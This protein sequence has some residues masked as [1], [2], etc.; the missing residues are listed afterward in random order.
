MRAKSQ[1]DDVVAVGRRRARWQPALRLLRYRGPAARRFPFLCR[2]NAAAECRFYRQF[3]PQ[4]AVLTRGDLD[5]TFIKGLKTVGR[6]FLSQRSPLAGDLV[7]LTQPASAAPTDRSHAAV[8]LPWRGLVVGDAGGG[9][10]L[11]PA[12]TCNRR[13]PAKAGGGDVGGSVPLSRR[14]PHH[15]ASTAPFLCGPPWLRA[16]PCGWSR[17][18]SRVP[19]PAAAGTPFSRAFGGAR[20]IALVPSRAPLRVAR[21][22]P[23]LR[24]HIFRA[25]LAA[26][27]SSRWV[28]HGASMAP[29]LFSPRWWRAVP[30]ARGR[31]SPLLDA[32]RPPA[33]FLYLGVDY[34]SPVHSG[35]GQRRL[36]SA[37]SAA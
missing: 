17:G 5:D 20:F 37:T 10:H 21:T 19:V 25:P 22:R 16:V 26:R 9:V 14:Q 12:F 32:K 24:A 34:V 3:V 2:H 33:S 6:T 7:V 8:V 11:Q 29:F 28:K 13:S 15:G 27:D 23:P 1:G 31:R 4:S 18:A 30:R 35:W 36:I